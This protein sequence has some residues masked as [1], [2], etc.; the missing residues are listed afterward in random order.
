MT[1]A[2]TQIADF[3]N[4]LLKNRGVQFENYDA[5]WNWSVNNIADFWGAVWE[6]FDV[7][8]PTAHRAVI[9]NP[10]MLKAKWFP[11]AQTNYVQRLF[12]YGNQNHLAGHPAIIFQNESLSSPVNV[13]WP[14]LEH[15]VS[16]FAGYLTSIGVKSGDR[17]C[18]LVS[19][20]P[21]AITSFLGCASIGA[22]WS[23]CSIEMGSAGVL[24][25]FRQIEP[26]VMI[27]ADGYGFGGETYDRVESI[28]QMLEAL[29]TVK[30]LIVL[31][32]VGKSDFSSHLSKSKTIK[33]HQFND[34]TQSET[35]IKPM[36]LPFEHPMWI[37][38]SSGTTGLPKPIVHS[39][40]GVMI[41][42]LKFGAFHN[43][44]QPSFKANDRYHWYSNPNWII[45]NLQIC[46]L[47]C[48]TTICLYDG[49]PSG[50]KDK[51]DW[52][53][54]W[55]F[56]AKA[57]ATYFGAGAAF[58]S[59]CEKMGL[60]PKDIADLSQIR[61]VGSTGS[62]LAENSYDWIWSQFPILNG[63]PIWIHNFAGGTDFAGCFWGGHPSL[64]V[65][66]GEMQVR[67]LGAAVYAYSEADGQGHGKPMI[68]EVGELVCTE[69]MPSMPLYFWN[70]KDGR[71]YF[72]SYFDVYRHANG[73]PIWRHG[74]WLKITDIGS[75]IIYGRSDTT[76]NRSGIRMGTAELYRAVEGMKDVL[77]SLV[78]D[79]EYLGRESYM[80]LFVVLRDGVPL[81]ESLKAEI[82][83][84]IKKQLTPKHVPSEILQVPSIPRTLSGKKMELPVKKILL[85]EA[86]KKVLNLD[87]MSNPSSIAWFE[88]FAKQKNLGA[89][90]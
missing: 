71:R 77:D 42:A 89:K 26:S 41:E 78:I 58:Y 86:T 43:N 45:W 66:K 8:S 29:P 18:A 30:D 70:D 48:G 39:H 28:C 10:A 22:I 87:A 4:W 9:E 1:S 11:G 74:D 38:F 55:K 67:C 72:E 50:R 33:V 5:L 2:Q 56:A 23:A 6:Y 17:V 15:N 34:A 36:W 24:D 65:R 81:S 31:P 76:I 85:G 7:D 52:G 21:Q 47:M 90:S 68:N 79:F 73:D 44:L 63:K 57:K 25:R 82:R 37:V 32:Q 3:E 12:K 27:A 62:P 54:L 80:P 16:A 53:T 49:S 83:D 19:N 64:P 13:T 46:V 59:G 69:P 84:T 40:G 51:P 75:G 14:E 35:L 20:T 88:D 60:A 61:T